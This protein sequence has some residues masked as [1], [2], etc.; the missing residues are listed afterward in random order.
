M[1][2]INLS[3]VT[4]AI[5]VAI[6][7]YSTAQEPR[8]AIAV[9]DA[10]LIMNGSEVARVKVG[11]SVLILGE[12]ADTEEWIAQ[13]MQ[14]GSKKVVG[15]LPQSVV[16]IS[17]PVSTPTSGISTPINHNDSAAKSAFDLA[18]ECKSDRADFLAR[19]KGKSIRVFGA[20][21][22][23]TLE[24][25][26]GSSERQPV[27]TLSTESGMPRIK[28]RLSPS[29]AKSNTI[30]ND[31]KYFP[32]WFYGYYGRKLEFRQSGMNQLEVRASY[33][34]SST[35]SAG[36]S[37]SSKHSSDWSPIFSVGDAMTVEGFIKGVGVDIEIDGAVLIAP[38]SE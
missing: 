31:Y 6:P 37:S 22:K 29:I 17:S 19:R 20:I 8:P 13:Y 4:M 24:T 11:E 33:K 12:K 35:Y 9:A 16:V 1:K 15:L 34:R 38:S 10:P 26:S 7:L 14:D 18:I 30:I 32:S 5:M 25:M 3:K 21:E 2:P 23:A 27:I 36:S 28:V